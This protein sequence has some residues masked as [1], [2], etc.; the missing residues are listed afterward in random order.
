[1]RLG[2]LLLLLALLVF[3]SGCGNLV[4]S[5]GVNVS[6]SQVLMT[7]RLAASATGEVH[8]VG[9]HG[10]TAG[11]RDTFT[12]MPPL[13]GPDSQISLHNRSAITF[14]YAWD[15]I[16][17]ALGA[18]VS[19]YKMSACSTTLCGRVDGVAPLG[20]AS[21]QYF[22]PNMLAGSLGIA[23]G[24]SI[25]LLAGSS[26]ILNNVPVGM[27]TVGPVLRFREVRYGGGQ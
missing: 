5:L 10:I 24:G 3:L 15:D 18:G 27:L 11:V 26:R 21:L 19:Q 23:F 25:E 1:M 6:A 9:K 2:L 14:G 22:V 8:L 20:E 4:G 13:G 16:N 12:L 17:I 7:R